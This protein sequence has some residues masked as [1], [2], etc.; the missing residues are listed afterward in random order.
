MTNFYLIVKRF[1]QIKRTIVANKQAELKT[2]D[3]SILPR[4]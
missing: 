3:T 1:V 4:E 2:K